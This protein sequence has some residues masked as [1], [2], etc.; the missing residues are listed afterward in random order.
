M[1]WVYGV[2]TDPVACSPCQRRSGKGTGGNRS[3][4]VSPSSTPPERGTCGSGWQWIAVAKNVERSGENMDLRM[5]TNE[6]VYSSYQFFTALPFKL[7]NV[8][9]VRDPPA[10]GHQ[11]LTLLELQLTQRMRSLSSNWFKFGSNASS[12]LFEL[13]KCEVTLTMIRPCKG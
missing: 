11:R 10:R 1:V 8:F 13:R 5:K 6:T 9:T 12:T 3:R 7:H 4:A 2:P